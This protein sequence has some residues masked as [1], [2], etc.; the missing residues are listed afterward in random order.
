MDCDWVGR[1][2]QSGKID[3][4]DFGPRRERREL[5][6]GI[7]KSERKP[8]IIHPKKCWGSTGKV[9]ATQFINSEKIE[10]YNHVYAILKLD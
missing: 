3:G 4:D 5:L 6:T 1:Q 7:A 10:P 9:Y 2:G 8:K